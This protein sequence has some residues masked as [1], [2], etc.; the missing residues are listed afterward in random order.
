MSEKQMTASDSVSVYAPWEPPFYYDAS[1]QWIHDSN[2]HRMLDLRGWGF[3]TGFH[4]IH[5]K[6]ATEIQ[7]RLGERIA[8]LLNKDASKQ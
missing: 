2:G 6:T 4:R 8:E 3:L 7:D 1:G 5:A